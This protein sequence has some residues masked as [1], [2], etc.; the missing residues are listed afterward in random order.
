[1]GSMCASNSGALTPLVSLLDT[2]NPKI[3]TVLFGLLALVSGASTFLLPE[4]TGRHLPQ[5]LDVCR[6][7]WSW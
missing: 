3:P 1:M 4:T 7:V 5:S 6:K 2:L